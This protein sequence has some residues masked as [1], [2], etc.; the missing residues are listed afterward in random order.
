LNRIELI[1]FQTKIKALCR[2][3]HILLK[4]PEQLGLAVPALYFHRH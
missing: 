1:D 2:G 3:W 4:W